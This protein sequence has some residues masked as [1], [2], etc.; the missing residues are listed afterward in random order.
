MKLRHIPQVAVLLASI[1]LP[2]AA[3]SITTT[4]A[5]G[6]RF[7]GNMFDAVIGS[8]GITVNS[9]DVN[10]DTGSMTID[11]YI[12]SGSYVG[13]DTTPAAWT[14]VSATAVTGSGSGNSTAVAVTPFTLAAGGTYGI[15]VAIDTTVNAAPFMYYTNSS[16]TYSN[17][18]LSLSL[19]EG[20]GGVFGSL[21]TFAGRTWDGTINYSLVSSAVP[22]PTSTAM[23]A[24]SAPGLLLLR[25]RY[26]R[27]Y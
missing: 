22:E 7:D 6:N 12:K 10:V 19:G 25:R 9:L 13:F 11:V 23:L 5:G 2:L 26:L 8:K 1:A 14:L 16:N 24:L 18:D 4:F 15:Y 21:G 17:A 27:K 20:L 3:S